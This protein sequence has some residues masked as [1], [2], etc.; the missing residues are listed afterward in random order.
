MSGKPQAIIFHKD[1]FTPRSV[2]AWLIRHKYH[3]IKPLHETINYLRARL[4]VPNEERYIYR[5]KRISPG[6]K[7]VMQYKMYN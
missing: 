7:M 6:V 5:I 2:D 1:Y 3:R 4:R